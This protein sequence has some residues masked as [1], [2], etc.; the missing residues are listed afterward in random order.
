MPIATGTN[1]A[2]KS[3]T[4]RPATATSATL[5]LLNA[6]KIRR[7]KMFPSSDAKKTGMIDNWSGLS[8][9]VLQLSN[10]DISSPIS[11]DREQFSSVAFDIALGD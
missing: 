5:C 6:A 4:A 10:P 8:S 7:V 11:L 9:F 1:V 2:I 3:V